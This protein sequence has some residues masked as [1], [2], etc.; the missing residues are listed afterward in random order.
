M[1]VT[2]SE[3]QKIMQDFHRQ[4]HCL[5]NTLLIPASDSLDGLPPY[6]IESLFRMKV[7]YAAVPDLIVCIV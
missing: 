6:K 7:V 4:H 5:P 1:I 3:I 2:T